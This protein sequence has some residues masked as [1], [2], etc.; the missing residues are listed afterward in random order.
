VSIFARM[1]YLVSKVRHQQI[2]AELYDQ[3]VLVAAAIRASFCWG[4]AGMP[5]T[6]ARPVLFLMLAPIA[7]R[8]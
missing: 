8:P 5:S 7:T 2:A 3:R 6:S 4:Q 1:R